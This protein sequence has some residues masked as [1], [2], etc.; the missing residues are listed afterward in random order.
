M[1]VSLSRRGLLAGL[2][3]G[4]VAAVSPRARAQSP[5]VDGPELYPGERALA[6]AAQ[7]EGLIVSCNTSPTWAN[8][9]A[10][11]RAFGQRYPNLALV[12]NAIGS[13]AAVMLLDRTRNRPTM[14]SVYYFGPSGIDAASRGVL[15][16][17]KPVNFDRLAPAFRENDGLWFA[18]HQMP[19]VFAVNRRLVRS[20]PRAWADL[21]KP[22]YKGMVVYS[23]PRTTTVGLTVAFA[24]N[25]AIGGTLDSVQPG[26]DFLGELHQ[27]GQILRVDADTPY[28]AFL[29]GQVPIWLTFENDGL[30][31]AVVDGM[32]DQAE[33]VL[34]TDGTVSVPYTASLV[35]GARNDPG[36]R[37]WLNFQ[38]TETGQRLFAEGLVRPALP[39]VTLPPEIAQRMPA[40]PKLDQLDLTRALFRKPDIDRGWS[41]V[42]LGQ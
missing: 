41:R 37:L 42:V 2:A 25:A 13:A 28:A 27:A 12:H 9:G 33:V 26:I 15:A 31:A 35:R 21:R 16:P 22:D 18:V 20:V 34:P 4:G 36:A 39:G 24:A 8:Y 40:P 17:F 32:G 38:V 11:F 1:G 19:V 30:R 23:D 6:E 3:A 29:R 5:V 10:L 7:R 14:D